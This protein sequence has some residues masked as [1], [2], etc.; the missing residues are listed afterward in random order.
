MEV[1]YPGECEFYVDLQPLQEV[2]D[3]QKIS[4]L[5]DELT[6]LKEGIRLVDDFMIHPSSS[7]G[8]YR[9]IMSKFAPTSRKLVEKIDDL[10]DKGEK[11]F[12]EMLTYFG[13]PTNTTLD[14]FFGEL[15]RFAI[16]FQK[17]RTDIHHKREIEERQ[18]ARQ[19]QIE[20]QK[21]QQ[22]K[23]PMGRLEKALADLSSGSAYA[24]PKSRLQETQGDK[25]STKTP[26]AVAAPKETKSLPQQQQQQQQQS[27][28]PRTG[29]VQREKLDAAL[30]FF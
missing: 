19:E 17:T 8:I 7:Y 12:K 16:L 18:K 28:T 30:A 22:V 15:W 29:P 24:T 14:D 6:Q 10:L 26:A 11:L 21:Q 13:E 9:D 25:F 27:M 4:I 20:K 2:I 5:K 1:A 23:M 3:L